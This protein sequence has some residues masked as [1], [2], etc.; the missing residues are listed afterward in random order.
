MKIITLLLVNVACV[1]AFVAPQLGLVARTTKLLKATAADSIASLDESQAGVVRNIVASIPDLASKPDYCWTG[2]SISGF[3]A[4][5]DALD[6][7]GPANIAWLSSLC[8]S[9]KISSLT[10]FN[11]P[12]TYVPHLVSRCAIVDKA[13]EQKISFF[14]DYRPRAY[15]AYETIRPDGTYPGPEELGRQ[16]FEF[17]GARREFE[18]NFGTAEVSDFISSIMASFENVVPNTSTLSEFELLTRGPLALDVTMPLTDVNV[19]AVLA[20]R[21]QA[22][23]IWLKW[24]LDGSHA[25]R[26]GAPV[27]TQYVYDS[28]Y[29]Q[30][31]YS[32]LLPI[33][34]SWFG[35][36]DG[37]KLA[38]ADSGPLDEG[39]VGGGS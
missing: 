8:V 27:N 11:G 31:T 25:H 10:I 4:K 14:L 39:Y 24:A 5:L 32:A 28:K 37:G 17:S 36:V 13:M 21:E 30:N 22:A 34:T 33:H 16:A 23:A 29:K 26:P 38:A 15:G 2:E 7:P 20:A 6:A 12:L 35:D 18:S 1:G 9:S 3:S 19:A